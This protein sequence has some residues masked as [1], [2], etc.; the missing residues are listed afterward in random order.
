M[1]EKFNIDAYSLTE[2]YHEEP[3][4]INTKNK[5]EF[6]NY[7]IKLAKELGKANNVLKVESIYC[8]KFF[9]ICGFWYDSFNEV[10]LFPIK[11]DKDLERLFSKCYTYARS[12]SSASFVL[13]YGGIAYEIIVTCKHDETIVSNYDDNKRYSFR[14]VKSVNNIINFLTK[15]DNIKFKEVQYRE[16]L[17]DYYDVEDKNSSKVTD[18]VNYFTELCYNVLNKQN[19]ICFSILFT[20]KNNKTKSYYVY[21]KKED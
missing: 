5:N 11:N 16:G 9:D 13:D 15:E 19:D 17:N 12:L 10:T 14:K 18:D 1:K 2:H 8:G 20:D 21:I 4:I 6:V 7:L 3:V